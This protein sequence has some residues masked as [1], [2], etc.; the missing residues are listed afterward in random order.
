MGNKSGRKKKQNL[1]T[2]LNKK[3]AN[4]LIFK[5]NTEYSSKLRLNRSMT[6]NE[7][8]LS[9]NS[10][11]DNLNSNLKYLIRSRSKTKEK[12]VDLNNSK[13]SKENL[14][15]E[16]LSE[17][18]DFLNLTNKVLEKIIS[19]NSP[20]NGNANNFYNSYFY[21]DMYN[22]N[23]DKILLGDASAV[24][25][26]GADLKKS[27]TSYRRQSSVLQGVESQAEFNME[28]TKIL[29]SLFN[30]RKIFRE[31][32]QAE[33]NLDNSFNNINNNNNQI[34]QSGNNRFNN[35]NNNI[36][37]NSLINNLTTSFNLGDSFIRLK[38]EEKL[39]KSS[40]NISPTNTNNNF[41]TENNNFRASE[42]DKDNSQFF[43]NASQ[44]NANINLEYFN[45]D[46]SQ[47]TTGLLG[48]NNNNNQMIENNNEKSL[49]DRTSPLKTSNYF[50]N[51][52]DFYVDDEIKN[53]GKRDNRNGNNNNLN[54]YNN[55]NNLSKLDKSNFNYSSDNS[56][57]NKSKG[58]TPKPYK[59]RVY[60]KP[61][62]VHVKMNLR[63]FIKDEVQEHSFYRQHPEYS[64]EIPK[65]K[66]KDKTKNNNNN[67]NNNP[68]YNYS[69]THRDML[70]DRK[71]I[72]KLK[73]TN[74]HLNNRS[75][76]EVIEKFSQ[77]KE[78]KHKLNERTKLRDLDHNHARAR[79]RSDYNNNYEF[80]EKISRNF[81]ETNNNLN[82]L[83]VI[84]KSNNSRILESDRNTKQE[85]NLDKENKAKRESNFI[86]REIEKDKGSE[87][88]LRN[89]VVVDIK[90]KSNNYSSNSMRESSRENTNNNKENYFKRKSSNIKK[91]VPLRK[92]NKKAK[93]Y[94]EKNS[95]EYS[96]D[97]NEIEYSPEFAYRE[98]NSNSN[99]NM[100]R[101]SNNK[102]FDYDKNMN[103]KK[104][105]QPK[106]YGKAYKLNNNNEDF[107][108]AEFSE[109]IKDKVNLKKACKRQEE[110]IFDKRKI[111]DYDEYSEEEENNKNKKKAKVVKR[112][113]VN[114][115]SGEE[116]QRDNYE[117]KRKRGF[118]ALTQSKGSEKFVV[119]KSNKIRIKN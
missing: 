35:N 68:N 48:L 44:D 21:N 12:K 18:I 22:E 62:V 26:T 3:I 86:T 110:E 49:L 81:D 106:N 55:N 92:S 57:P 39:L 80:N 118:K 102:K 28:N 27:F 59:K 95:E 60:T 37:N 98:G 56:S 105:E 16:I 20:F 63:D 66:S 31:N 75:F 43:L 93:D 19:L 51:E 50:N 73:L 58:K 10:L 108:D 53:K 107:D 71:K 90:R 85:F 114:D 103:K 5:A 29:S 1:D 45:E 83:N 101:S 87:K 74:S 41:N 15:P 70:Y 6:R 109:E 112:Q 13:I 115:D 25:I 96:F 104:L 64:R 88:F 72:Q 32:A 52:F 24:N 78:Y 67:N 33:E 42:L 61:P 2:E 119:D 77:A 40:I 46:Q 99:N 79:K 14:E 116:E 89:N 30:V 69:Q 100:K 17:D 36:L 82:N 84:G 113:E 7:D 11:T 94:S 117:E 9:S 38:S 76:A 4:I 47:L 97:E 8:N 23:K 65:S 54:A 91:I 34:F 111:T